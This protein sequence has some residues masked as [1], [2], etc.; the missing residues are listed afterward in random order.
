MNDWNLSGTLARFPSPHVDW[1]YLVEDGVQHSCSRD[2]YELE[3]EKL[4]L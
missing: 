1:L 2:L 3:I 4:I